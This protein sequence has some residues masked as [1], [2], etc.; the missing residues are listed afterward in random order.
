MSASDIASSRT[1]EEHAFLS[2]AASYNH[3]PD[4]IPS[5]TPSPT[6]RRTFSDLAS[7]RQS[8]S[9]PTP[10]KEDVAA[11]KDI[12]RRTSLQSKD[13]STIAV[14]RFTVSA[15]DVT[16]APASAD[17]PEPP[18]KVPVTRAPEPVARPSKA[19]AMSGRLVSFARKPWASNSAD[20][21]PSPSAKNSRLRPLRTEDSP[22]TAPM[23]PSRTSLQQD[24]AG[25]QSGSPVRKRTILS[26]RPRRPVV[27][28]VTQSRDDSSSSP[29]SP[30]QQSLRA[31][32]SLEKLPSSLNVST[33]VLPPV[34]KGAATASV[35][36]P[37][38]RDELWGTFR[39][40]EADFQK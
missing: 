26:K 34:P 14:S 5:D 13:K 35:D 8:E 36:P 38:K 20:R 16:D 6:L 37:R 3:L 19:R 11:G 1:A 32:P 40:L 29:S 27:A 7:Q 21:A 25:E 9:P 2:R 39:A 4:L 10:S 22:P 17:P 33:P 31:Q 15:E 23:P 30:S 28:V 18:P 12:L 24:S